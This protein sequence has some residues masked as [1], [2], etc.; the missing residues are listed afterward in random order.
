MTVRERNTWAC[1]CYPRF[2]MAL[3]SHRCLHSVSC[4][5]MTIL[6]ETQ[7]PFTLVGRYTSSSLGAW[8][9]LR[10]FLFVTAWACHILII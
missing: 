10:F 5:L 4:T 8:D 9:R 6:A 2:Y 3:A 7:L 1:L